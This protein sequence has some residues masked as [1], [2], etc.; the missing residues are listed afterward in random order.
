MA[1]DLHCHTKIS[2]GSMGI[3]ELIATAKRRGVTTLAITDHDA[4]AGAARAVV[5]GKRQGIDVLPGAEFSAWDSERE[6]KVHIL[7]YL[8]DTPDRLEGLCHRMAVRRREAALKMLQKVL[9]YYPIVP[10]SVTRHAAGSTAIFKQHIMHALMD[11]GYA[12]AIFGE[13]YHKLFNA[14]DGLAFE[15][16]VYPDVRTVTDSIRDAGGLVVIAHP[17]AYHNEELIAELAEENRLDGVEVW[18]PRQNE[19]QVVYLTDFADAHGLL[20][21]GGTDFHGMY[22]DLV[23]PIG[24]PD[25]PADTP[26]LIRAYKAR[27]QRER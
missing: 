11:A 12:D 23:H 21:T 19:N 14:H 17:A 2:D 4:L 13:T 18:H 6:T 5:I 20:K 1:I 3:D 25:V 27:K 24:N 22:S 16:V 9:R 15:T 26:A 10:E 8:C 7:A